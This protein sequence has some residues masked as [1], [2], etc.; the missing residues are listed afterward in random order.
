MLGLI[1]GSIVP[2]FEYFMRMRIKSIYSHTWF[3]LFWLDLP[4]GLLI[5][6]IYQKLVKDEIIDHLPTLLNQ[7]FLRFKGK[8]KKVNSP[9]YFIVVSA[10]ILVGA[11]SHIV[12][13]G[14][15][16]PN[17]YFVSKLPLLSKILQVGAHQLS[18]YNIIQHTSTLIGAFVIAI[19]VFLMP[20]NA[21]KAN[22]N[23]LGFWSQVVLTTVIILVIR[24]NT[25][26]VYYKYGDIIVTF[27]AG[28]LLGLIIASIVAHKIETPR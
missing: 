20:I 19:V 1:I 11:I 6:F 28:A 26:L 15:T 21:P 5:F 25:G 14:F 8:C 22:R 7:R 16:H 23:I 3:G 2:D 24:L 18:V 13:D 17:S 9:R 12:W 10:S 4:L 27:I